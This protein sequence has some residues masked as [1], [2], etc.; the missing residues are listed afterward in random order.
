MSEKMVK[1]CS[2]CRKAACIHGILV[3]GSYKTADIIELPISLL[4]SLRYEDEHYL[5]DA[6]WEKHSGSS[7]SRVPPKHRVYTE[8]EKSTQRLARHIADATY[9]KLE[10]F[11]SDEPIWQHDP[12]AFLPAN[13]CCDYAGKMR[14]INSMVSEIKKIL[15][16]ETYELVMPK[17]KEELDKCLRK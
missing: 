9:A 4:R 7:L 10:S 8:H 14:L 15:D 6:Y 16:H 17:T 1:V 5:D 13:V 12:H 11:K 2:V 3:C